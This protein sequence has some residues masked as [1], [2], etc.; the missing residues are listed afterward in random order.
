MEAKNSSYIAV[1]EAER[2]VLEVGGGAVITGSG[3]VGSVNGAG[4]IWSSQIGNVSLEWYNLVKRLFGL[5]K[6]WYSQFGKFNW[7]SQ[8]G[9]VRLVQLH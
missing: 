1:G 5:S 2:R 4:S 8:F 6:I 3:R 7:Y 9:L